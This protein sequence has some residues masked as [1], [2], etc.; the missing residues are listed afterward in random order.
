MIRSNNK[1]SIKCKICDQEFKSMI[2]STHLKK[3]S[4]TS[5]EYKEKFGPDSLV[6]DEYRTLKS[7]SSK[8]ENNGMYGKNHSKEMKEKLSSE[9]KGKPNYALRGKEFSEEH[10]AKISENAKKRWEC[11]EYKERNSRPV[12]EEAK[13]KISETLK[14]RTLPQE[15]RDKISKSQKGRVSSMKGKKHTDEAR[16]NMRE[17]SI[18][19]N[20]K[21]S[22]SS[23]AKRKEFLGKLDV[24]LLND[25][26][27]HF[28][29]LKCNH[30]D[31]IFT[32]TH[33]L[34]TESKFKNDICP[35][36]FPLVRGVTQNEIYE[37]LLENYPHLQSSAWGIIGKKEIDIYDPVN[38]I[39]I[40]YCGLYWHSDA[41]NEDDNRHIDKLNLCNENDIKLITVFEDEYLEKKELVISKLKLALGEKQERIY[42][43]KCEVKE[44]DSKTSNSFLNE[45]HLQGSGRS[46]KR[47]GIFFQDELVSVMT[48]S[49]SNI[50][51]KIKGWEINRYCTKI[52]I[53]VVG[54]ASKLFK[55]FIKDVD[56][57]TVISYADRRWSD[58]KVYEQ[59]GFEFSHNSVPN[60]WYVDGAKRLHRF[61]MRKNE[62]DD[63]SLTERENRKNQGFHRIYDCGH[64][65]WVWN[66]K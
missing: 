40:E 33:Q 20:K 53:T 9:R 32:R 17:A 43:R 7:E 63:Q 3:H 64:A 34:L 38:R 54:G 39:G 29:E 25:F 24:T 44:I 47:Y 5:T 60:Y 52:G 56:P 26:D 31:T 28:L 49:N 27:E 10:R 1:M 4:M 58:G 65:K 42:A 51:R 19:T 59:L 46:N 21:K 14:G 48:F 66:K 12:S 57:D 13:K 37:T 62:N 6:S 11:P 45:Y 18:R 50:S 23:K 55:A 22:E 30:C 15:T 2:T 35:T 61:A 36:C 16:A 8:G 41:I